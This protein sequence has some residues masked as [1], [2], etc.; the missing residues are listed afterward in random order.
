M[1]SPI[2]PHLNTFVYAD[3]TSSP[4]NN[5]GPLLLKLGIS[6]STFSAFAAS[7]FLKF[8]IVSNS[9]EHCTEY[10]DLVF[11]SGVPTNLRTR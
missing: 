4:T 10:G 9:R 7:A 3:A 2:M 11:G 1:L 5:S 8:S 6:P